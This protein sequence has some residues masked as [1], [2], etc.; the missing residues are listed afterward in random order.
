MRHL[1]RLATGFQ[2][3][4]I[5][6]ELDASP[7]LWDQHKLRTYGW[8]T[9]H[10]VSDIWVRYRAWQEWEQLQVGSTEGDVTQLFSERIGRFV[11]EQH[12]TV[13][14]PAWY[15][16]PSLRNAVFDLMHMYEVER[17]GG[18]LITRIPPH[19]EVKPHIDRGW[20]AGYYEKIALQLKSA[21]GQRF[22]FADGGF[23]CESG[24]VYAF[25]NSFE[26]WVENPTDHER[27]TCIIC[28]RRDPRLPPLHSGTGA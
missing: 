10:A 27:I 2:I 9:P 7:H 8:D 26:H 24:T 25:D 5:L 19:G 3:R 23:E 11:G 28:V 20:H 4:H 17:L 13:N 1:Q 18:V 16:L 15:A 14:Y 22:C 21:L 6:N 12:E